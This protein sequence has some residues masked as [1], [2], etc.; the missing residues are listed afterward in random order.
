MIHVRQ[1]ALG[2]ATEAYIQ[3]EFSDGLNIISSGENHVGKTVIMQAIMFALGS[4][5]LFPASLRYQDYVFIVDVEID[6]RV[7]SVLRNRNTFVVKDENSIVPLE[8]V[9][10]FDQYWNGHF[11]KLPLI[12]K[13]GKERMAPAALFEQLAFMPQAKR[14]TA[15]IYGGYYNK[16]DFMEMVYSQAG[17]ACRSLG[18]KTMKEIKD[19]KKTLQ[20]RRD[21]LSKQAKQLKDPGTSLIAVSPTADREEKARIISKLDEI[22]DDIVSLQNR[23]NRTLTRMKKNEGVLHELNSLNKDISS[24]ALECLSC[25]SYDIGY[26]MGKADFVFNLTTSDMRMQILRSLQE[27][28]NGQRDEAANLESEIR[29]LQA[30]F[31]SMA[32]TREI[33]LEDIFASRE[34][35]ID[36]EDIDA[37]LTSIADELSDIEQIIQTDK[38]ADFEMRS[39]RRE[40]KDSILATMNRVRR[41]L[42]AD[43]NVPDYTDLFTTEKGP[44]S[45]SEATEFLMARMYSLVKHLHHKLPILVDSFRAEELSTGREEKLLP[46]FTE[47]DNQVILTVTLK[48]QEIGKYYGKDEINNIDLTD[49]EPNKLLSSAYCAALD[50]KIKDFGIKL[51]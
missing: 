22:R 18:T 42:G 43:G 50:E 40:L 48:E 34:N 20:I 16:A 47:L 7:V 51:I 35:Y 27:R 13:D 28:I 11:F 21:E 23:R 32:N 17:L 2:N 14:N 45:G 1:I 10:D 30:R 39:N 49:Y 25:G 33:T 12:I 6:G 15:R 36:L 8:T 19:R 37:E 29:E 24:G 5:P 38:V 41:T 9:A 3:S 31:N 4:E 46:F 44:Y 26:R